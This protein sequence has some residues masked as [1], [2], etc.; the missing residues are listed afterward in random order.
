MQSLS[1]LRP[2]VRTA[3][4]STSTSST[5]IATAAA[6]RPL[7][8]SA[9]SCQQTESTP[10]SSS[11]SEITSDS[12]PR[13]RRLR[14][15]LGAPNLRMLQ[16][17]DH[18]SLSSFDPMLDIHP[19][20]KFFIPRAELGNLSDL[21]IVLHN[22]D[23]TN[24]GYQQ[25]KPKPEHLTSTPGE[26]DSV[27]H[28]SA[29]TQLTPIEIRNLYRF[30]LIT[31]R[32]VNMK[33]KGKMPAMYSLVVVGNGNGLVGVGEGKDDTANKAVGKA[34]NQAVR[35]MDYVERYEDRT[36]WGTMQSNFGSCQ[37]HM[38]SRAPGFGLRVNH[39][40][41]QV[42]K[43]AGISDLSA[44]VHGSRN[45]TRVIKLAV[46]MLHGGSTPVDMGGFGQTKGQRKNKKT[47]GMATAD[48]V[49]R[50]RGRKAVVF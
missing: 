50:L 38:R 26:D 2:L 44:K 28:L 18:A 33:S 23:S 40:I 49:A 27:A 15:D 20:K 3:A 31:K 24:Q 48:E 42:A 11:S 17:M 1:W 8:S 21:S 22:D 36:I 47:R 43:A 35:S 46:A 25:P 30:P 12:G 9:C 19:D 4:T 29:V 10:S 13:Q 14:F 39:Y 6:S 34:F 7:S 37:I 16:T 32:V 5:R 41:H 45:G